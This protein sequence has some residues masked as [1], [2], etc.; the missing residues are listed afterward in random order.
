MFKISF[1]HISIWGRFHQRFSRA[2]FIRTKQNVTRKR[3]SYKKRAQKTLVKSTL[4]VFFKKISTLISFQICFLIF[5]FTFQVSFV[6]SLCFL[7]LV[8]CIENKSN[9]NLKNSET[10]LICILIYKKI[11]NLPLRGLN[12]SF[13]S[14]CV[15]S[16]CACATD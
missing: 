13:E 12:P 8:I 15:C 7:I 10:W 1:N 9:K 14:V 2:F 16:V 6:Q 11:K 4:G 3:R 5:Q